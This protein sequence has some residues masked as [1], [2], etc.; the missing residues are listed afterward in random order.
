MR[1]VEKGY[2]RIS[3]RFEERLKRNNR[4]MEREKPNYGK[5][6]T[7]SEGFTSFDMKTIRSEK[8]PCGEPFV[9]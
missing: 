6:I 5:Q 4:E 7:T 2:N 8:H 1:G 3:K 9:V